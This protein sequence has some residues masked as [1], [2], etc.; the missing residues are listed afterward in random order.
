MFLIEAGRRCES[1][2]GT[3]TFETRQGEDIFSR[4]ESAVQEQRSSG[5][6]GVKRRPNSPLPSIPHSASLPGLPSDSSS[7]SSSSSNSR[8]VSDSISTASAGEP[9]YTDPA[10]VVSLSKPKLS[11]AQ[12]PDS[13]EIVY[14]DPLDAIKTPHGPMITAPLPPT[15]PTI[16]LRQSSEPVYSSPVNCVC[17][18]LDPE[19]YANTEPVYS[20]VSDEMPVPA[21]PLH[22]QQGA[23]Y[24]EPHKAA[25]PGTDGPERADGPSEEMEDK[26]L[27]DPSALY[28]KVIKPPKISHITQ[29]SKPPKLSQTRHRLPHHGQPPPD[30]VYED[31]GL[32]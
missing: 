28:S 11:N 21:L 26:A 13:P 24:I 6:A 10:S 27:D 3:F 2:P 25:Y 4:I 1:G 16:I 29:V 22:G 12:D 31:L 9:I 32:I 19:S 20:E 5:V 7:S 23:V 8:M 18:P 14:A 30:I 15:P 17:P